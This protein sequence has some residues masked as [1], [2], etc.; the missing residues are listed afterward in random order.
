VSEFQDRLMTCI[1]CG[2]NFVWTAE[3]QT[4]FV[5]KGFTNSPKRCKPCR[6]ERKQRQERG[7]ERKG[8]NR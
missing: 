6:Q 1:V 8:G 7:S 4:F 3:E 5:E 2:D